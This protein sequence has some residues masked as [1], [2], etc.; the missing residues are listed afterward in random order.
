MA[1]SLFQAHVLM[2]ILA[3]MVFGSTG[4]LFARYGRSLR[5]GTRRQFLGKA[6]WFQMH[7]F[8][9]SITPLLTLLGFLFMFVRLGGKWTSAEPSLLR[10]IHSIFGGIVL[11]CAVVQIWLVLYRCNPR[12]PFRFL[13]DWTHRVIGLV[14]MILSIPTIFLMLIALVSFRPNLLPIFASWT[15]WFV[16][17]VIILERIQYQQ[18]RA[19]VPT[20][21]PDNVSVNTR[22]DIESI[23]NTNVGSRYQNNLKLLLLSIH[24]LISISL[25]I[26]FML[27]L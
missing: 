16:I 1:I 6:L 5:L 17:L 10:F 20:I 9:L 25:S 2:M 8:L 3:W 15:A 13:F 18:Q 26:V 14:A 23:G 21:D 11:C 22:P 4:V 27:F 7:R 24:L 19:T 12:S